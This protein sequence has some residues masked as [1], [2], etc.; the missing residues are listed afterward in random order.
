MADLTGIAWPP[1][2]VIRTERSTLRPVQAGDR[3]GII[4]LQSSPDVRRYLGGPR[5]RDELEQSTPERPASYPGVFAVDVGGEF[6][7]LVILNRRS[8][9]LPGH[10]RS[11]GG[12]LEVSYLF[13]PQHWGHGYATEAVQAALQWARDNLADT[14]VILITQ[15]ANERSRRVADRLGFIEA[16]RFTQYDA[17]QWVGVR[18]L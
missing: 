5:P 16:D 14:D 7:G 1:S 17:L 18:N 15:V 3:A 8:A 9:D 4:E 2:K 13:L 6:V 12:E 11:E 10:V